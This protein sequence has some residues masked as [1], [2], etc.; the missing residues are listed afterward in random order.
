MS[1][2]ELLAELRRLDARI[3]L[4]GDRLR[5]N[6]PAG[7]LTDAHRNSIRERKAEIVE[8]LRA[9]AAL[10]AQTQHPAIVP[11]EARGTRIPIFG[12]GGHNGDVFCYRALVQS[13]GP[14]QPFYGLQPPG[15]E[16]GT[17]P[18]GT[19]EAL[20]GYF[21][22]QIRAVH[23]G[24]P[25][26]IAGF[27][28]GGTVAFE[29]ARQLAAS[30]VEVRNVILFGSPFSKSYAPMRQRIAGLLGLPRRVAM[31]LR[32][33][34]AL[35]AAERRHYFAKRLEARRATSAPVEND[36]V[37]RRREIV[38]NTTLAAAGRYEPKP[39][40]GP[41]DLMLPN[42]PWT[43]TLDTPRRWLRYATGGT[44]FAGPEG[45]TGD[46]MLLP[47]HAAIFAGAVEA[48]QKRRLGGKTP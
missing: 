9:A 18:L 41:V 34:I 25:L 32:A 37:M 21:A 24:G 47:E 44:E 19:I 20:A 12:A 16:E 45:C 26:T 7:V 2:A 40:A 22:E 17:E 38:A 27:C 43:R 4:D 31:H 29:L 23:A 48:L 36:E 15:I 39:F 14:E 46:N 30:G 10:A 13:L 35:P 8:F 1:V 11:L 28:A 42:L 33:L 3:E 6:A 5:L